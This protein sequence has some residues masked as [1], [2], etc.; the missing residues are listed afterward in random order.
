MGKKKTIVPAEL[1]GGID[2]KLPDTRKQPVVHTSFRLSP[3]A[4]DAIKELSGL[5][6]KHAEVFAILAT[7][8]QVKIE[9]YDRV[10]EELRSHPI[11]NSPASNDPQSLAFKVCFKDMV[12]GAKNRKATRK[13]YAIN[14]DTIDSLRNFQLELKKRSI[15]T[16]RDLLVENIALACK[17]QLDKQKA[18][19]PKIYKKYLGEIESIWNDL[20]ELE[21]KIT[22]ELGGYDPFG[23]LD[24]VHGEISCFE[25]L[26]HDLES[27]LAEEGKNEND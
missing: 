20:W 2:I 17:G 3:E 11:E 24:R 12:A 7:N 22:K 14:K 16:N 10:I 1:R 8:I 18:D 23:L 21:S 5:Y 9:I 13:T 6:G 26:Q 4:H 27:F 15:S 19:T 25:F